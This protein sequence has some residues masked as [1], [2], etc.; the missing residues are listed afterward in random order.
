MLLL[1]IP[2]LLLPEIDDDDVVDEG[3]D[4]DIVVI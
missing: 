1:V 3:V 4:G 2:L